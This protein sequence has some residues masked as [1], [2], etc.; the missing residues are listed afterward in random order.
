[1]QKIRELVVV[2]CYTL[3]SSICWECIAAIAVRYAFGIDLVR[4]LVAIG[5]P[6]AIA[7][8]IFIYPKLRR[9][10]AKQ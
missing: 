2:I 1:M 5:L 8:S 3:T 9:I 10:I 6:V 4:A 7:F